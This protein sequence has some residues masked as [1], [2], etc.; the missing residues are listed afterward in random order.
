VSADVS[1]D[2]STPTP[3]TLRLG[4]IGC[5]RIAQAAHLPAVAKARTVELVAVSDPSETLATGVGQ[6]YGV[7]SFTATDELLAHDLDAV[8][9][10]APDRFHHPLGTAAL[11][12]GKHVLMEKPLAATSAEATELVQLAAAADLRLQTGAMKRHDPAIVFAHDLLPQVGEVLSYNAV[13]RVPAQ[14]AGIE[15]TLFPALMVTDEQIR[16]H[17]STFKAQQN[18]S[19]YLLATHGAHVFDMLCFFTG[20]PR[21]IRVQPA[22]LGADFTWHGLVGLASGGI[23]SFEMT[24]DVHADWAEGFELFGPGGHIRSSIFQP[25]WK[26]GSDVEVY[27]ESDGTSRR[28]HPTDTNAF[29]RQVEDFADAIRAGGGENPSPTDGVAAVRLIEAA[30]VSA[31]R[32]GEKV[33]L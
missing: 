4:V 30:A 21:W 2:L 6:Q 19:S 28:P 14:R 29:K 1:A 17:E 9:I 7:P 12:A 31:E 16:A 11:R 18:R 24:V 5:G 20:F 26:R 27:L 13:Y 10:A 32:D 25:F 15:S 23:G 22:Q 33:Q 3:P 8:V